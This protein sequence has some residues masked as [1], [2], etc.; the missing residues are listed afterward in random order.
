MEEKK[1]R[2][3]FYALTSC[4]GC[5]LQLAMMDELLKLLPRAEIVC[6]YMLDRN[7]V[8]DEPVDIAFIEGSVSTEEEV[9]LVKKIRENAKIVVAVGSCAV[10]G[11][12][13]SW[14]K[15]KPLEEL[16]KTV[17][18]DG[19]VKFQPKM[20]EPV[21]KYIKVDYNIYG[22]PPEKKD[23]LYALGTFLVGSWPEDIDY[24]VC[25]ECRLKGNPCV[26]LERGE[27]CLGPITRAGCDARCPSFGI[28]C[29]G[30]RGAIGYDVAWFD[31]LA[32][33]FKEKGLT[34]EEILERMK[35]FNAHNE[36]LEEMVEKIFGG[37]SQ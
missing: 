3:G 8:E 13:Q 7:S 29:I 19:K 37:E 33:V 35:I 12:V 17:Y 31:S 9:E 30:C 11:G 25:L 26:L 22:C 20:A 10:Q 18:G 5:Q 14:E 6:W 36:K 2:I 32:R 24:P 21:S 23:F 16:W 15:D 4:Y 28:A 1:V 34:K 27:P